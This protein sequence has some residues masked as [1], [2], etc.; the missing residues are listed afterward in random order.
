MP[1]VRGRSHGRIWSRGQKSSQKSIKF[2]VTTADAPSPETD[3]AIY[4]LPGTHCKGAQSASLSL[5][6]H[7]AESHKPLGSVS[8][9]P[10]G[11]SGD[12]RAFCLNMG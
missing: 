5:P 6:V 4:Q 11:I 9:V 10:G 1:S 7:M 2:V 8:R 12:K 3:G